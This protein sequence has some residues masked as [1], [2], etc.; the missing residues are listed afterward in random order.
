MKKIS[1]DHIPA[2]QVRCQRHAALGPLHCRRQL[3]VGGAT[4]MA[5][6]RHRT[7]LVMQSA[8]P[9]PRDHYATLVGAG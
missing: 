6:I 5:T 8:I 4:L 7:R 1:L 2:S 3:S 9:M